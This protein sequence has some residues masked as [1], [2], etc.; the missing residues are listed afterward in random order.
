MAIYQCPCCDHFT[1]DERTAWEIC[2]VCFR[3]DDGTDVDRPDVHSGPNHLTLREGRE[4]VRRIGACDPAM[5]PHVVPPFGRARYD[6]RERRL[7]DGPGGG[8]DPPPAG[9]C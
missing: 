9:A 6:F 7:D 4:N 2:P 1:L 3:E 8:A 5:L